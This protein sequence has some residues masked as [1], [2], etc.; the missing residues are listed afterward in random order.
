MSVRGWARGTTAEDSSWFSSILA[1]GPPGLYALVVLVLSTQPFFYVLYGSPHAGTIID[2]MWLLA[3]AVGLLLMIQSGRLRWVA[4]SIRALPLLWLVLFISAAS[5]A[6]SLDP[7]RTLYEVC[8]M[9]GISL[10]G[11]G[12]GCLLS[13]RAFMRVLFWLFAG[14]LLASL[15]VELTPLGG[16][17][18]WL[19]GWSDLQDGV[20]RWRGTTVHPNR[21]GGISASAGAF[22]VV[23]LLLR[24]LEWRLALSMFALAALTTLM[25][26]SATAIVMLLT[27]AAA[28]ACFFLGKRLRLGGDLA[29]LLI[30]LGLLGSASFG[31]LYWETS[32]DLLG[33]DVTASNRTEVWADAL[34]IVEYRPFTGCGYGAVWGLFALSFFP[35]F[36]STTRALHAHNAY[37][38]IATELGL[39]AMVMAIVLLIQTLMRSVTAYA[40]WHSS[41]A[42]FSLIYVTMFAIENMTELRMFVPELFNW[43]LFVALATALARAS[44]ASALAD[45][46]NRQARTDPMGRER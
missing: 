3:F 8:R 21:L 13:P 36:E 46:I 29:A 9:A 24:R 23:A 2:A 33:K 31:L 30:A 1:L 35:E 17:G 41:F 44:P 20:Y 7:R 32:T 26:R 34:N 42:L 10:I 25:T 12:L 22:F 40:R 16:E 27:G 11:V 6:W 45:G 38:Q 28:A 39:P 4:W 43:L 37:L 19:E 15:V 18:R 5:T 14:I